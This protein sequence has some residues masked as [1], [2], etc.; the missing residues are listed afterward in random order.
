[1]LISTRKWAN[2]TSAS[3][4]RLLTSSLRMTEGFSSATGASGG[5]GAVGVNGVGENGQGQGQG[6][7][8]GRED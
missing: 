7:D 1:M 5:L 6:V 8:V 2:R 4:R 3:S